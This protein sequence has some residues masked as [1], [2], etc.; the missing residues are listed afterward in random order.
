MKKT[1]YLLLTILLVGLISGCGAKEKNT[2]ELHEGPTYL[3]YYLNET[4][5]EIIPRKHLIQRFRTDSQVRELLADFKNS[6][7]TE[8]FVSAYPAT[9]EMREYEIEGKQ[10]SIF[11]DKSY[12]NMDATT[13]V[14][15]RAALVR[16]LV[17]IDGVD[18]VTFYVDDN[19]LKDACGRYVGAMNA[20]SFVENVGRQINSITSQTIALYLASED[21]LHLIEVK[22][23]VYS[24]SNISQEKLVLE[25]LMEGDGDKRH[26]ATIPAGTKILSVSTLD[27]I[28][29]VNFDSGFMEHDYSIG[30]EINLYSIVNSLCELPNV[31]KVQI[32]VNGET[33]IV[34][35]E[36]M[37]FEELYERN[38]DFVTTDEALEKKEEENKE[39]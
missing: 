14:L 23:K 34:Y 10:I 32:S 39:D 31:N 22:K 38:L 1:L 24:S 16:T 28:C 25:H 27:G 35:R 11:F 29:F 21:G 13:E 36:E 4:K 26:K 6:Y 8:G 7:P 5:N 30:E 20:D 3:V 9:L 2:D 15:F 19:P 18:G 17:Q 33:D 37:T 12:L